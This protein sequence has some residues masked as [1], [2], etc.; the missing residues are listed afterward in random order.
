M[1]KAIVHVWF[2]TC[3]DALKSPAVPGVAVSRAPARFGKAGLG[4]DCTSLPVPSHPPRC[5]FLNGRGAVPA[6]PRSPAWPGSETGENSNVNQ[7]LKVFLCFCSIVHVP[8]AGSAS[9]CL[10]P[11]CLLLEADQPSTEVCNW[12]RNAAD[13]LCCAGCCRGAACFPQDQR[14][15]VLPACSTRGYRGAACAVWCT[16]RYCRSVFNNPEKEKQK[17]V[18]FA[19]FSGH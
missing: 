8:C 14:V 4:A 18:L 17:Q 11:G 2:L 12:C 19:A 10:S 7:S 13:A 1:A 5:S 9:F 16:R 15:A 6:A 3:T